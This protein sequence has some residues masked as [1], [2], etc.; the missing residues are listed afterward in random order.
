MGIRIESIATALPSQYISSEDFVNKL[1]GYITD[2]VAEMLQSMA[3]KNRYSV[4]ENYPDYL[5]GKVKRNL[6]TDVNGLAVESIH[7]CLAKAKCESLGLFIAI[8]NTAVRPLPCTGYEILS[9]VSSDLI[10]RDVNV[11]NMQNQ[12]CSVLIKALEI[13]HDYLASHPDK[14]VLIT[15]SEA[16]TALIDSLEDKGKVFSFKELGNVACDENEKTQEMEKLHNLINSYLF[17][18]GSVSLLLGNNETKTDF[19]HI[20]N[21]E[22][23]DT[24]L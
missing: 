15:V 3:I 12:G 2:G 16:H 21:I 22:S 11:V 1:D 7:K 19:H 24:E 17:G 9:L 20:T 5:A 4:V 14:K 23:S 13:G 6:T 18:D 10:P 8:T